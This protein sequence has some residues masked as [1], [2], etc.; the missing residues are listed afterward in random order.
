MQINATRRL[1]HNSRGQRRPVAGIG[2][3]IGPGPRY[4]MDQTRD[5]I[6]ERLMRTPFFTTALILAACAIPGAGRAQDVRAGQHIAQVWCSNCHLAD[7]AHQSQASDATPSFTAIAGNPKTT[8]ASLASFLS[9]P[10]GRMP[11]LSLS[12]SDIRDL[13]AYILSLRKA[14]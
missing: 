8:E 1:R 6:R 7:A 4:A 5:H 10:H 9:R 2:R 12:Q 13:A 14:P 3:A 11:N